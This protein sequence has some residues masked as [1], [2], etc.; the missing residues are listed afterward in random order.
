MS[1]WGTGQINSVLLG[2][3]QNTGVIFPSQSGFGNNGFYPDPNT[4][5]PTYTYDLYIPASYDGTEPYGLVTFIN[6]G[7]NGGVISS[8]IPVLDEK[9]LILV[10]G[11]NIGNSVNVDIR[12]GVAMAA[13]Y[14]LREV[15]NIEDTRIYTS[16]NSGGARSAS[17]LAYTYPEW[18]YGFMTN[19]GCSYLRTVDQDYETQQPNGN[20]EYIMPWTQTDLDYVKSFDRQY[21]ILTSYDDFR[22]GDIMNIYHN[23]MEPDGFRGKFLEVPGPHCAT[24]TEHFRDA[25][26]FVEHPHMDVVRDSFLTVPNVGDGFK[27]IDASQSGGQLVLDHT[28]NNVARAY[29]NNPF[30]WN[31]PKGAIFRTEIE[32][33]ATTFNQNS[34]VNV[35]LL[36]FTDANV[37]DEAIGHELYSG[38]PN[39]LVNVVFDDVQPTVHILAENPAMGMADDTLFS[40][41]M[42]DWSVNDSLKL[43]FHLWDQE[44]RVELSHHFAQVLDIDA[45][46]VTFLDDM[47]SIQ[48]R[49]NG[50]YWA[51]TDF[52]N[53]TLLTLVSG[54]LNTAN[55]SA[56]AKLNYVH[57]IA[58][59][60]DI[61]PIVPNTNALNELSLNQ[62]SVYPNPGEG[63][64]KI[65]S[66]ANQAVEMVVTTSSGQVVM[67]HQHQGKE[68]SLD[69]S[70]FAP[71]VYFVQSE[72]LP[73]T[74]KLLVR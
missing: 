61:D 11:D 51:N 34:Y 26:N 65:R 27:M 30:V 19:C 21:A 63:N 22:E 40:A 41:V 50:G 15:L 64:F 49:T 33:D 70:S 59:S 58:A 4:V 62:W 16:G 31:D 56:M 7:N 25:V 9:K 67:H 10:S 43:K 14:R 39:F 17:T 8:W 60:N 44:I 20:Y 13:V 38:T 71:G 47:R 73:G 37:Y 45:S 72:Q 6:S 5:L 29:S 55:A 24:S 74:L 48:I 36:D 42:S 12:M 18:F 2:D 54:K 3:V 52:S 23:G 28:T 35:G 66:Q 46:M 69:L 53:G 1:P 68:S 32:L 57:V